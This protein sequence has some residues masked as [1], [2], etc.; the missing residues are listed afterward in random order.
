M[1]SET[2]IGF[3][4]RE[5]FSQTIPA[6]EALLQATQRRHKIICLDTMYP[7]DVRSALE[8]AQD[9]HGFELIQTDHY[10]TPNQARNIIAKRA[11][12]KYITFVDNDAFI[13]PGCIERLED[14]AN[15]SGA[16]LVGPL[17][18]EFSPQRVH[19]A[20]GECR[21][22]VSEDGRRRYW[23][24]HAFAHEP[25]SAVLAHLRR[26]PTELI[27][28]HTVLVA[29]DAFDKFGPLDEKLACNFEHW[30]LSLRVLDH[31]KQVYIEPEAVSTYIPPNTLTKEDR[32]YFNVRW[33]EAWIAESIARLQEKYGLDPKD[34]I[35]GGN[36][37]RLHRRHQ[38]GWIRSL[39]QKLK[40]NHFRRIEKRI[41]RPAD[42]AYNRLRYGAKA[43]AVL[44][45]K[46]A[47]RT[48]GLAV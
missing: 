19:M 2:T 39:R 8:R 25:A 34:V 36:W 45:T 22:V 37:C 33:S 28:F 35:H 42:I 9:K 7:P 24:K 13:A 40:K 11:T 1:T 21:I 43:A 4:V 20:G 3:V 12:T 16:W 17:Y 48:Y 14:C 6:L 10:L 18:C 38:Y 27:E 23:E 15:G 30:D 32:D 47:V 26:G 41:I 29:R 5:T 31:G 44:Q 46:P